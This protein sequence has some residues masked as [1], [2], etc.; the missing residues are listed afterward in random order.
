MI[1]F[2]SKKLTAS[3]KTIIRRYCQFVY[4]K[5]GIKK[6]PRVL[7]KLVHPKDVHDLSDR[8]DLKKFLA[9]MYVANGK[10]YDYVII[11][12]ELVITKHH[13]NP[14]IRL[15]QVLMSVGHELVHIK[16]YEKNEMKDYKNGDVWFKGKRYKDWE[17]ME[18]YYFTPWEIESYGYEISLYL[19][20]TEES[21]NW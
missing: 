11:I 21:S 14:L 7:I 9:W 15:R 4:D 2:N 1:A 10:R 6:P 20:F 3:Q 13:K 5:I 19:R 16:Q 12:N 8:I 18:N 17:D